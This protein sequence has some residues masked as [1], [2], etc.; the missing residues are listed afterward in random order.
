MR[1]LCATGRQ[2][3]ALRNFAEYARL[4]TVELGL[5]PSPSLR[6]LQRDIIRQN[7]GRTAATAD[8]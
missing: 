5:E 8:A 4:V 6:D 7:A 3:E 1:A 2:V